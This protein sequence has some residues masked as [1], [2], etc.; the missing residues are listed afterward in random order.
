MLFDIGVVITPEPF[1]KLV[2]QGIILGEDGRKMSKRWD[3]VV[4]PNDMIDQFG[5]DALRMFEMFMGPLEAMK[6]WSSKSVEGISRFLDRVWRLYVN[7]DG[8]LALTDGALTPGI[9]RVL[10]QT[11][12][13]V[14]EDIESLKFNT[15]IA[16]MMVFVNEVNPLPARPRELLVPFL[17]LMGP[18]APHL[19]EEIWQRLGHAETLAYE[20][21]PSYDPALCVEDTVTVAVQVNGKLRAT[22]DVARGAEQQAGQ[23]LAFA[24]E[25]VRRYLDGVQVRKVIYV[26]DKLLN[27]VVG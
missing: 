2:H 3:N 18:F 5:A 11:I 22:L 25:R 26:K 17:K 4:D 6:P 1:I 10:H 9:E 23:D 21:W 20:P 27:V 12:R 16:Q 8:S 15:A 13:K 7:E 14:T 24:D 19:S